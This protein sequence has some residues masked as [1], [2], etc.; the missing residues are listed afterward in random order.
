MLSELFPT[1]LRGAGL[2]FVY[3]GGRGVS[4]LAPITQT[5]AAH[6]GIG[7]SLFITSFFYICG[8][9]TIFMLPETKGQGLKE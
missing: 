4:A 2:G 5:L 1:R 8:I 7:T 9:A 3:N 6:F